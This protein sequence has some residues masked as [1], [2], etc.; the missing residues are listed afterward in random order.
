MALSGS[1]GVKGSKKDDQVRKTDDQITSDQ[2]II[3][4]GLEPSIESLQTKLIDKYCVSC[5]GTNRPAAGIDLTDVSDSIGDS[6]LPNEPDES[7]FF[8]EMAEGHMPPDKP[9]SKQTLDVVRTWIE[10]L[11]Q[12]S[13][14]RPQPKPVAKEIE[15][16]DLMPTTASVQSLLVDGYCLSCHND[17]K[18]AGGVDLS[19]I[20][21]LVSSTGKI[22]VPKSPAT[23]SIYTE[24][25]EGHMPPKARVATKT[26]AVLKTWIEGLPETTDGGNTGTDQ[27]EPQ[28]EPNLASV[29]GWVDYMC[30]DCHDAATRE[31]RQIDL[32]DITKVIMT[33]PD[34]PTS[35]LGAKII[36]PGKPLRSNFYTIMDPQ[37][38]TDASKL[39]PKESDPVREAV[40]AKIR[41]WIE[42][43]PAIPEANP[44]DVD[45]NR[46]ECSQP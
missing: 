1:C 35:G 13:S 18:H 11:D 17:K 19:D 7:N 46:P 33:A 14:T 16:K 20:A 41:A 43:L 25:A 27:D 9:I 44:C 5:H 42:G 28:V 6:I 36:Y 15:V 22:I 39:M 38:T 24:I 4:V 32:T 45:P 34:Q 3:V 26:L 8:T 12:A 29:Q 30:V 10:S 23:S 37:F 40:L 31:N 2:G 21:K